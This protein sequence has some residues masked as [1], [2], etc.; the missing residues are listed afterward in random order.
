MREPRAR[1]G[2]AELAEDD[3]STRR[4]FLEWLAADNFTFL[5]YRDSRRRASGPGLGIL[6]TPQEGEDLA[7]GIDQRPDAR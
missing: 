6:R 7:A 5:G 2:G 3:E 4:R 1:G